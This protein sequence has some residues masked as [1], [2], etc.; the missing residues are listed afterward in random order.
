MAKTSGDG[1]DRAV[2]RVLWKEIK[3]GD[4]RKFSATANDDTDAGGGARDLRFRGGDDLD[5]IVRAMFPRDNAVRRRRNGATQ[6]VS[7]FEGDLWWAEQLADGSWVERSQ[8]I[9]MEPPTTARAGEWRLT[10]VHTYPALAGRVPP[11]PSA[12]RLLLLLIQT[13]D[14]KIW[15]FFATETSLRTD[16][17]WEAAFRRHIVSCLDQWDRPGRTLFGYFEADTGREYSNA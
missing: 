12:G 5:A 10:R 11:Q 6:M 14:G 4:R 7:Q 9:T 8:V 16:A 1:D 2:S 15:P 13:I 17:S 3:Q